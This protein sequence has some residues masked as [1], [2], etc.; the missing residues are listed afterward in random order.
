M[1]F[2]PIMIIL[3]VSITGTVPTHVAGGAKTR[4][5]H[6]KVH[7]N[8]LERETTGLYKVAQ[9]RNEI[10]SIKVV[11][12]RIKVRDSRDIALH[13]RFGEISHKTSRGDG[14]IDLECRTK[15]HIRQR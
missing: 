9:D 14:R 13:L 5:V 10:S 2:H 6:G 7:F 1:H 11:Q 12:D 15:D 3:L 4:G 8:R